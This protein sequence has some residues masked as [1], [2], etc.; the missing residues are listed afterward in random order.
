MFTD[1]I[2][3]SPKSEYASTVMGNFKSSNVILQVRR[4]QLCAHRVREVVLA[5]LPLLL[6][7]CVDHDETPR[8]RNSQQLSY[9][10]CSSICPQSAEKRTVNQ[11]SYNWILSNHA[12][13]VS[14]FFLCC[15]A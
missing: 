7:P 11:I 4:Q 15:V 3:E 1:G 13:K 10:G 5:V 14:E 2:G 8:A 6:S 9:S 12:E